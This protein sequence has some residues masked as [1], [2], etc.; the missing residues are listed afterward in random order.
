MEK[1]KAV[2]E[3]KGLVNAF[4]DH[5]VHDGLNLE[6]RQDEILGIIGGSGSGKSVLLRTMLGL[7][8]P[9]AGEVLVNGR[10]LHAMSAEESK[11]QE[12]TWGVLFQ[13]GA[14]FSGMSTL[15]NVAFPLREYTRLNDAAIEKI[16]LFKLQTT[17]LTPEAAERMPSSLSGGMV[18]RAGLAR[19]LALDPQILFL[20]EPTAGLDPLAAADFD[21]LLL[22][23]RNIL[24]LT[25]VIITHDLD[26]LVRVCDRI[27]MIV[28]KKVVC[29][30]LEE[31]MASKQEDVHEYFHGTRMH[32]VAKSHAA[33]NPRTGE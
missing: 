22:E 14:L 6:V 18:K 16:A 5:V 17:G 7:H 25:V 8:R 33:A 11:E 3:V 29:G 30:T 27:A 12:K 31:M 21:A 1:G 24:G 2:I 15:D 32:A 20:D 23:L 26:T 28:D 4:G 10:D 19:A 13:D 9:T